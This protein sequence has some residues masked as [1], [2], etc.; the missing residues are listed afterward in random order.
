[1][2][3][4]IMCGGVGSRLSPITET[5][6]KPMVKL[7]NRPIIDVI[8]EKLIKAGIEDIYLSLGYKAT[9]IIEHCERK[10][11]SANIHYCTELKPLGTAGGV[12]NCIS[13]TDDDVMVLSGDNVFDFDISDMFLFHDFVQS[14]ITV[15]AVSAEDPREYGV[16]LTDDDGSI[17][18]FIEKPMWEQAQ[19]RLVNTG[20]YILKGDILNMIPENTYYDFSENL[21]PRIFAEDK[22]FMCYS[23]DGYWGDMG[24][25]DSYRRIT[26]DI[27]NEKYVSLEF[28]FEKSDITPNVGSTLKAPFSVGKNMSVGQNTIVDGNSVIGNDCIL[29]NNC[30]LHGV[31]LGD[32]CTVGDNCELRNCIIGDNVEIDDNCFIEENA[33][34]GFG[35]KIGRFSRILENTKI[36]PGRKV[37]P[38]SVIMSDMFYETPSIAEFDIFGLSGTVNTQIKAVDAVRLGQAT[39]SVKNVNKIGFGCNENSVGEI[40]KNLCLCAARTCGALCYDFGTMFKSQGYFYS[41]YCTL[42]MFIYVSGENETVNFSFFGKNGMPVDRKIARNIGN[43][44]KYSSFSYSSPEKCGEVYNMTLFSAVYKSYFKKLTQNANIDFFAGVE[45]EN[46]FIKGVLCELLMKN[47]T[48]KGKLQLLMNSFGSDFYIIE[49]SKIYSSDRIL[50]LLCELEL[51][52]SSTVLIPEDAPSVIWDRSEKYSGVLLTASEDGDGVYFENE[53]V[54]ANIW[55]FD[56]IFLLGKLIEVLNTG[57][58]TLSELFEYQ[59]DFTVRRNIVEFEAGPADIRNAIEST[60]AEKDEND[61]YYTV[62]TRNGKVRLRQLGNANKIRI[63]AEAADMETAREIS[64]DIIEKIRNTNID[65]KTQK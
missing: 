57:K 51:A 4:V 54:L 60:G 53:T 34:I 25:F 7:L 35:G 20:I 27:L 56:P 45:C 43:N 49:N 38:E 2:K 64:A 26:H 30:S 14:D 28:S 63:L 17:R 18:S 16:I 13:E 32:N 22:R 9:D 48:G 10:K 37:Y 5:V 31:I 47:K 42:D 21:F 33:V 11:F 62:H 46:P 52:D 59:R 1:M 40:Y 65:N 8:I 44:C 58:L 41:A 39:A 24:Q 36:W 3:A 61:S 12:K 6:P 50:A 15:C 19:S 23:S 29:G 55:C